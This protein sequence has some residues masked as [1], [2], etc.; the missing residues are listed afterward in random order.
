M[1]YQWNYKPSTPQEENAAQELAGKLNISPTLCHLLLK[2]G[3][4]TEDEAR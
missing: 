3:I 1:N 4:A 2:R